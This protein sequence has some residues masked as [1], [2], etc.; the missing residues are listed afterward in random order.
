[1]MQQGR[2]GRHSR[3]SLRGRET[4]RT[5]LLRMA[6]DEARAERVRQLK[7]EHPELTW[8]EIADHVGVTERSAM[9]WQRTGGMS[10]AHARRLA[11]VMN[12]PVDWIWR[13]GAP[14]DEG[15]G[16]DQLDR[17]GE[18]L[19]RIEAKLDELLKCRHDPG[20]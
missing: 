3:G 12:A 7:Q 13:G 16:D 5:V 6:A 19:A 9:E 4:P 8:R 18:Q 10:Y 2:S 11:E 17:I 14:A 20:D 1:M 15:T